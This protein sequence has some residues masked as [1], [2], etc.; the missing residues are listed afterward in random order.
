MVLLRVIH[1]SKKT[2]AKRGGSHLVTVTFR[3]P[4]RRP[5]D[6]GAAHPCKDY[7]T[8]YLKDRTLPPAVIKLVDG[9]G[10]SKEVNSDSI[11]IRFHDS[12]AWEKGLTAKEFLKAFPPETVAQLTFYV[13]I[14]IDVSFTTRTENLHK[15]HYE[16]FA[17]L[18]K[19]GEKAL[20]SKTEPKEIR[21]GAE[22]KYPIQ[23]PPGLS[24]RTYLTEEEMDKIKAYCLIDIVAH[25]EQGTWMTL[26]KP[27]ITQLRANHPELLPQEMMAA[28]MTDD[29]SAMMPANKELWKTRQQFRDLIDDPK[30]LSYAPNAHRRAR[31]YWS[32]Y[33][34]RD[35]CPSG[36]EDLP[37][38]FNVLWNERWADS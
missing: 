24:R 25:E 7:D 13:P 12:Y 35:F 17:K 28:G 38:R 19:Y 23:W 1:N 4:P 32:E 22:A 21:E 6:R 11:E 10:K 20:K 9:E 34:K 29:L 3:G 31:E 18:R 27:V 30:K 15:M 2:T 5:R 33:V 8:S 16:D 26:R 14:V 36:D 37:T